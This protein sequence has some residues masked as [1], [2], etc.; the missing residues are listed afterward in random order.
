ME[1]II[2]KSTFIL[3]FIL[4]L[5]ST[6]PYFSTGAMVV[7]S[8]EIYEIDYR[9]PETHSS[10]PPP[11]HSRG[12]H[13]V[14]RQSSWGHPNNPKTKTTYLGRKASKIHG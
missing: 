11:D 1:L 8:E 4:F 5:F 13:R 9:G 14:H 7:D 10:I 12:K 2:K 3:I 6:H